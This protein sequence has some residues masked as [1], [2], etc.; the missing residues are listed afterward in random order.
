WR[1]II[2]DV[3]NRD[4]EYLAASIGAPYGDA[5]LAGV[6]TGTL[7]GYEVINEWLKS[8]ETIKPVQEAASKYGRLYRIYKSLYEA[9]REDFKELKRLEAQ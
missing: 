1:R 9:L 3:L 5:L 2:T 7:K 6:G 4:V 8:S